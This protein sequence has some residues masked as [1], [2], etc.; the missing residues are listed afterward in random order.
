[1]EKVKNKSELILIML[2]V[3]PIVVLLFMWN[4]LP[5]PIAIELKVMAVINS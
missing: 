1:M 5:T 2:A 4:K 3:L